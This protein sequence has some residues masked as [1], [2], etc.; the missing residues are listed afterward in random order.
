MAEA[1]SAFPHPTRRRVV[2]DLIHARYRQPTPIDN[3]ADM[4]E[5]PPAVTELPCS[6]A[7]IFERAYNDP[8]GRKYWRSCLAAVR[9]TSE[10]ATLL[11]THVAV[12]EA[13]FQAHRTNAFTALQGRHL[14]DTA[15]IIVE[16]LLTEPNDAH[17]IVSSLRRYLGDAVKAEPQHDRSARRHSSQ[18]AVNHFVLALYQEA[19]NAG[20]P[21]PKRGAKAFPACQQAIGATNR[22][23]REA[24]NG[25]RPAEAQSGGSTR[26]NWRT[27]WPWRERWAWAVAS[28]R[29]RV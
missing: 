11:A 4:Y 20:L 29:P 19:Y 24:M 23:F 1:A 15:R 7:E 5:P 13:R 12:N 14:G 2:L 21:S 10:L 26:I 3:G 8:D 27:S 28:V 9:S 22:Q 17:L 16:R 25:T 18:E 6:E